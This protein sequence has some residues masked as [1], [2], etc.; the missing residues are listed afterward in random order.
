MRRAGGTRPPT[1]APSDRP[2]STAPSATALPAAA[3]GSLDST[4]HPPPGGPHDRHRPTRHR[5]RSCRNR[6]RCRSR[7]RRPRGS[8]RF[9]RR[10]GG[11][12]A[13]D[14]RH[15]TYP[16][17]DLAQGPA[18]G[19]ADDDGRPRGRAGPGHQGRPR[20]PRPGGLRGRP[21]PRQARG[22]PHAQ[23]RGRLG[24]APPG[25]PAP[26]GSAGQGVD[27][28]RTPGRGA[29]DLALEL[30]GA[31]AGRAAGCR[32]G[33][34]QLR[35][36]QAFRAGSR[37]QCGAGPPAAPLSGRQRRGGRGGRRARDHRPARAALRPHLLHRVHQRGQGG[38]GGSRQAPD[39]RH[40]RAGRQEPRH[41]DRRRRP[42]G[43]RPA[44]R[45]GQA[46]QRRPDLHR[47]RLR[48]GRRHRARPLRRPA[49]GRL[50]RLPPP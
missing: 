22:G 35:G 33:R 16:V 46:P 6:H 9:L 4:I 44:H 49:G 21:G 8:G 31:A 41:R 43:R 11:R 3:D 1:R 10:A 29:G 14:L 38:H 25:P 17:P 45:L 37:L 28:P 19:V 24:Q 18:S 13:G 42:R 34:G 20:T 30:P 12:P 26:H 40:P 32:A 7:R 39:P 5:P 2:L 15:R 36:R 50:Q 23:A 47:P 27:H 48:A